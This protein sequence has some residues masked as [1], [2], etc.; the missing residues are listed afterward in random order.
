MKYATANWNMCSSAR[1]SC[2]KTV[3]VKRDVLMA[4]AEAGLAWEEGCLLW[5][6]PL[7]LAASKFGELAVIAA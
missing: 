6:E 7:S 1:M 4:L 2:W 5:S 3:G